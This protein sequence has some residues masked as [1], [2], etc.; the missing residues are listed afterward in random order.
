MN[1]VLSRKGARFVCFD[2]K[3]FYLG[4]P[5][6]RP[7]YARIHL[8]DIPQDFIAEYNL[9]TYERDGWMYFCICKGF[10][11]LSQAGKL[12]KNLL[13]KRLAEKY[14]YESAR[15]VIVVDNK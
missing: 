2:V 15:Y 10:Y 9:T 14:Y 3:N 13:H 5:L 11:G 12:A 7:D 6:N 1:R 8:K 4:T